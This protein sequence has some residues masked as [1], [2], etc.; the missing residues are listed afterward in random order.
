MRSKWRCACVIPCMAAPQQQQPTAAAAGWCD[1]NLIRAMLEC[2]DA[3]D[4]T[5]RPKQNDAAWWMGMNNGMSKSWMMQDGLHR[6]NTKYSYTDGA[7][8]S[9]VHECRESSLPQDILDAAYLFSP[10]CM[11][12]LRGCMVP[13]SSLLPRVETGGTDAR[14][15][16]W[17]IVGVWKK[18]QRFAP[19]QPRPSQQQHSQNQYHHQQRGRS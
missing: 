11:V 17:K 14:S 18:K 13:T 3:T 10:H 19:T 2:N 16:R 12:N 6:S 9:F 8:W 4:G 15:N 1:R 7:P 5:A